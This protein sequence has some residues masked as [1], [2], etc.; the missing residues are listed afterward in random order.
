M[1]R[2]SGKSAIANRPYFYGTRSLLPLIM[3]SFCLTGPPSRRL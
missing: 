3:M 2:V 1:P